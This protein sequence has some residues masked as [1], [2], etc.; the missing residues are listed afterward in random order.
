MHERQIPNFEHLKV[1]IISPYSMEPTGGVQKHIEGYGRF[2]IE[3]GH[4]P[5][6]VSPRNQ[7]FGES[8]HVDF[9]T[10]RFFLGEAREYKHNGTTAYNSKKTPVNPVDI[11][12]V[13]QEAQPDIV[14]GHDSYASISALELIMHSRLPILNPKPAYEFVTLHAAHEDRQPKY[15]ILGSLRHVFDHLL[16][17]TI[18]VSPAT[19]KFAQIYYPRDHR[20]I[21]NGVET[22]QYT[23]EKEKI[24]KF[25]DGKINIL[26]LGRLEERKGVRYLIDAYARVKKTNETVRLIVAGDGPQKTALEEQVARDGIKD[27]EFVGKVTDEDRSKYYKT[28]DICAFFATHGEAQGLVIIEAMASGVPVVAGNNIGYRTVID[29]LENGLLVDPKNSEHAAASLQLLIDNEVLRKRIAQL[30]LQSALGYDWKKVGQRILDY[31]KERI[32]QSR[33]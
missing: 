30:G 15:K 29:H 13:Q 5:V 12:R 1:L 8:Q 10:K 28:A 25:M 11:W 23:E 6:L 32:L 18:A 26:Y 7:R 20:V 16:D 31:Y 4:E 24:E 3:Q 21:P 14:H 33:R 17:G 22:T 2:L 9:A 19:Q 27:V